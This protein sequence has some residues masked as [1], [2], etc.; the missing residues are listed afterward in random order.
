[1][2]NEISP[3][4]YLCNS[5]CQSCGTVIS[6]IWLYYIADTKTLTA[7]EQSSLPNRD[8]HTQHVL[9]NPKTEEGKILDKYGVIKFCCRAYIMTL[10]TN[11]T[12]IELNY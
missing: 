12:P 10:P 5:R 8:I 6:H 3:P 1:M 2:S 7:N 4:L 9:D 11:T